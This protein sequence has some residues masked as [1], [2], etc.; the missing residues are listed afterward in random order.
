M[1]DN[2]LN[3]KNF[4]FAP[5]S[6]RTENGDSGVFPFTTTAFFITAG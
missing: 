6:P 3:A 4:N 1:T 2:F 5:F